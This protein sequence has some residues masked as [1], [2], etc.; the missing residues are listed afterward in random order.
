MTIR[1]ALQHRTSYRFDRPVMVSPHEIRLR[2]APHCRPGAWL[3]AERRAAELPQLAA[4][5]IRELGRPW[6]FPTGHPLNR[7]RSGRR[8]TVINPF[9]F[10]VEL[11]AEFVSI[12]AAHSPG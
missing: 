3:F 9:D 1:V 8:Q 11:Y 7:R 2:P 6:S 12:R 5:S 4:G 10:F